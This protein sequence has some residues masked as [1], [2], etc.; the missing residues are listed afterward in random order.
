TMFSMMMV[1]FREGLEALLIA[2][3]TLTYLRASGRASLVRAA[4]WGLA[5]AG[6]LC[7]VLG[8]VLARVGGMSPLSEGLLALVAAVCVISCT[9]HMLRH[10]KRM[11]A[12]I[13][14][15]IDTAS[16]HEGAGPALAVF[17][18]VVLMVGR[19]GVEA[20]TM[21]AS[22]ATA[23]DM[24]HL[25][26]GAVI[27]I[28]LAILIAAA[29]SRYG[30]RVDLSLFFRVTAAF[31]VLFSIQLVIYAFHELTEAGALPGLDNQYW[32]VLTEPYGPEGEYGAWLSYSLVLIPLGF[33]VHGW[34]RNRLHA[35]VPA[36]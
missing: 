5:V 26:V 17:L 31:M 14:N 32:H 8:V 28:A 36:H 15:R 25:L 24:T 22:L 2:A 29:W 1:T 18:F 4:H 19:E 27:G 21:M 34:L 11:A 35:P 10:G 7:V 9:V 3:I 13:R 20:A 23:G 6:A 33:L 12:E 30:R 16:R